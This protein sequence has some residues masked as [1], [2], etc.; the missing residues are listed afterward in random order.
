MKNKQYI[1]IQGWMVNEL[2]LKGNDLIIYAIIYGFSQDGETEFRGSLKYLMRSTNTSKPTVIKS[3]KSLIEKGFIMKTELLINNVQF[4]TYKTIEL[5]VKN[6]LEGSKET[7]SNGS[8]EPLPNNTIIN[9]I[10]NKKANFIKLL[11]PFKEKYTKDMLN[12]FYQYWT[13]ESK[14]GK[15]LRYDSEKFFDIKRRLITWNKRNNKS[16]ANDVVEKFNPDNYIN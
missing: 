5:V 12:E 9:T 2:K 7:D 11:I 10:E 15:K 1:A 3:L 13:E 16:T 4:N 8:K 14:N 6:I